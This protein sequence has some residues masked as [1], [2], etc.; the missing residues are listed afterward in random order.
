MWNG[1][2]GNHGAS[3]LVTCLDFRDHDGNCNEKCIILYSKPGVIVDD[4]A[5]WANSWA[6]PQKGKH[7][8]NL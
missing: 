3:W 7:R 4:V 8:D 6:V 5:T 1:E 2:L